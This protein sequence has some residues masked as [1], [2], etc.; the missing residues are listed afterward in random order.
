MMPEG[1]DRGG[2]MPMCLLSPK[3]AL[4]SL[5]KLRKEMEHIKIGLMHN[6][7]LIIYH[8][9]IKIALSYIIN[10]TDHFFKLQWQHEP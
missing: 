7:C 2:K 8:H 1:F 10:I 9:C 3:V 4:L 6:A 5:K